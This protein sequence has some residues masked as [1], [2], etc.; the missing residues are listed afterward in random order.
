MTDE[1]GTMSEESGQTADPLLACLEKLT[2]HWH[3]PRSAQALRA[4]LPLEAGL[5][6]PELLVRAAVE[7]ADM[8]AAIVKRRLHRIPV[9]VCPV[10]LLM[11]GRQACLLSTIDLHNKTARIWLPD[12]PSEE[13]EIAL[14]ELHANYTGHAIFV[15]PIYRHE[16]RSSIQP[17]PERPRAW[18]WGTL[19]RFWRIYG[20]V[21][22]A[23]VLINLFTLAT[24][25]FTMNVYD[26]VVPNQTLETLWVLA[27]GVGIV[28]LFEFILRTLRGYLIDVAGKKAD[29]LMAGMIF[30][31][32]VGTRMELQRASTGVMAKHVQEFE[33]LR[34]FF[35]SATITSLIDLPFALLFIW[36]IWLLC[37]PLYITPL[38]MYPVVILVSLLLQWPLHRAMRDHTSQASHKN[39]VLVETLFGLEYVKSLGA[40]GVV[41][42]KWEQCVGASSQSALSSRTLSAIGVNFSLLAQQFTTIAVMVHGVY[43]IAEGKVTMGAL[44]ACSILSGR[45]MAPLGKV[46]GILVKMQQSMLSLKILNEIMQREEERPAH[47]NFLHRPLT[48]GAI[49]FDRFSFSYPGAKTEAL[50]NVSI[51]IKAGERVAV[52]G[53]I[54]SGKSSLLKV[55][56][57]LF[58]P[59]EGA[60]L[61]DGTD[62]RQIDPADLRRHIGYVPQDANLFYGTIRD[63][64]AFGAPEAD[65]AQVWRAAQ[66][67]GVTEFT[68]LHPQGLDRVVGE[69]GRGLSGGQ[70]QVI[71][72]ARAF[73]LNPKI[74]LM[75]EPTSDMDRNTE[76]R[77]KKRLEAVLPG[78][79]LILVTHKA[80]ML[81]LVERIVILDNGAI[82]ADGPKELVL[83]WVKE[84]KLKIPDPSAGTEATPSAPISAPADGLTSVPPTEAVMETMRGQRADAEFM[85]ETTAAS[86]KTASPVGR[87]VVVMLALFF[88][89]GTTWAYWA[90][91]DEVV[92][93][94]G[95]VIPS[96][97]VQVVQNLEGGIL[98]QINVHEGDL[99][100]KDQVLLRIDDTQ[101]RGT[102]QENRLQIAALDLRI[103][104]LEAEAAFKEFKPSEKYR[105][106]LPELVENELKLFKSRQQDLQN[107]VTI[108]EKRVFQKKQELSE[109]YASANQTKSKLGLV[110]KELE[111]SLPV[112]A[113]GLMS[114]VELLRLKRQV[115]ELQ[116]ELEATTMAI[117]R[118]QSMLEEAR[119][120]LEE[121]K[122]NF[123]TK[124]L[125]ELNKNRVELNQLSE[126][127][128][129]L[130]DRVSRTA[131]TSPVNGTV[132]RVRVTTLGQVVKPGVDLVE[133]MPL[134]D[135]LLIE[136]RIRPENIAFL[137]PGLKTMV[138]LTAYDFAIYGGLP[139]ELEH[140]SADTIMDEK[141]EHYYQI[142]VRTQKNHLE[143]VN[144]ELPI[145]PGMVATVDIITGEKSVL[146]YLLKP[147]LRA[148]G[149]A[150]RER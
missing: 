101:S 15:R 136:A 81:S 42:R 143:G 106:E 19:G 25:I 63:N 83:Q 2:L 61:L 137:S 53:R 55:I 126:S 39:A 74:L 34:D 148:K 109:L 123:R 94:L 14:E 102:F 104:R 71:A 135:S 12:L 108:L 105:G 132:I 112:V 116:K 17:A 146:D 66:A 49:G 86:W 29:V 11:K 75:D 33:S 111:L 51:Q 35:T 10:I 50:T 87:L 103:S 62:L 5:L 13:R 144:A 130:K 73:L 22:L 133:I 79:T 121:P 8:N 80:S 27:I 100:K 114:E 93:G 47:K 57:G 70:R 30:R 131:I 48:Q 147:I 43:L 127:T 9:L 115:V 110:Q 139:G 118:V 36:V 56:L 37:G 64:I 145:I 150:M 113:E 90:K 82:L 32:V 125:D 88:L 97:Q 46:A 91:L 4:G 107:A 28:Y 128:A 72:I 117:P 20:H 38:A 40:E 59:V 45:A 129:A 134:D 120:Q 23:T 60:V 142:R 7:R 98:A 89:I 124:A 18:F 122:N 26:R 68:N 76:E 67:A 21:V 54:G 92:V 69:Q 78:K 24:P 6:T 99:V 16:T 1:W 149:V 95:K 138:K 77:F 3:Q 84:G 85:P 96:S 44:F 58:Q 41:Q 140:I 31:H 119:Q 141:G 52:I 65:D